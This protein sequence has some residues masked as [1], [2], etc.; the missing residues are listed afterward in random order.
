VQWAVHLEV[1]HGQDDGVDQ[2]GAVRQTTKGLEQAARQSRVHTSPVTGAAGDHDPGERC[3][4]GRM[5]D[6]CIQGGTSQVQVHH[7]KSVHQ[8]S[9]GE[10][11]QEPAQYDS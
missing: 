9:Q 5:T 3:S 1:S 10:Q 7:V 4:P 2:I 8:V 6:G 11:R